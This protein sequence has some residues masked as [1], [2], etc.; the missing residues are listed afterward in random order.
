M[1]EYETDRYVKSVKQTFHMTKKDVNVKS[2]MVGSLHHRL[3]T[4]IDIVSDLHLTT[5]M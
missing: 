2:H 1:L 4:H 3:T 5:C